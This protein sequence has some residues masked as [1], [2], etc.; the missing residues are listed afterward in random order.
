MRLARPKIMTVSSLTALLEKVFQDYKSKEKQNYLHWTTLR[1]K[2]AR[3]RAKFCLTAQSNWQ[4]LKTA[5]EPHLGEG[6]LFSEHF[7]QGYF[8][9][10]LTFNEVRTA[11]IAEKRKPLHALLAKAK[12]SYAPLKLTTS[13]L[14]N[15]G[16]AK[17]TPAPS[18][19]ALEKTLTPFLGS[20]LILLKKEPKTKRNKET[21]YLAH[22]LPSEEFVKQALQFT[23][24]KKSLTLEAIAGEVPLNKAVFVGIFNRMLATGQVLVRIDEKFKISE[25]QYESGNTLPTPPSQPLP[26]PSDDFMLFRRAFEK[27]DRGLIYVRICNMRRELGWSVERFDAVLNKLW[28]DGIVQAHAGDRYTMT[29]EDVALSYRD[30][31]G[32]TYG[33]LTW[34]KQ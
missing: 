26:S 22:N 17:A 9:S 33:T 6:M 12:K 15:F 24:A 16:F 3:N 23:S 29:D 4:E 32:D 7:E 18:T 28:D 14:K 8:S 19:A 11:V 30:E 31:N 25:V 10:D 2:L 34:I 27:L 20:E 21:V 5:L 1:T 13:E